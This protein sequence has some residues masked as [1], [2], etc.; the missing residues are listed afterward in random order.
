[1]RIAGIA[2]ILLLIAAAIF[3]YMRGETPVVDN[4]ADQS[5]P[6]TEQ[7]ALPVDE[8]TAKAQAET[9]SETAPQSEGKQ[10]PVTVKKAE[11]SAKT[12]QSPVGVAKP[13]VI[14]KKKAAPVKEAAQKPAT[15]AKVATAPATPTPAPKIVLEAPSFDI[16]RVD[17]NCGLLVA[18]RAA[19][20]AII[21]VLSGEETVGAVNTNRRG[22]WVFLS[23]IA[24]PTSLW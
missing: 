24:N 3:F 11:P 6:E 18:G 17:E 10:Q 16:V 20:G 19:A 8:T 15:G 7:Q 2:V 13:Q 21:T 12:A 5:K 14:M 4:V 1:M 22:E 9:K 23:S